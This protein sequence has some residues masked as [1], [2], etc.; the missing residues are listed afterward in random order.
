MRDLLSKTRRTSLWLLTTMIHPWT[1]TQSFPTQNLATDVHQCATSQKLRLGGTGLLSVNVFKRTFE[2]FS[3]LSLL[4]FG[5]DLKTSD[6][7]TTGDWPTDMVPPS[8]WSTI[9][10]IIQISL[11][12][13][14]L[15]CAEHI[16]LRSCLDT[17]F[18]K[19]LW[20]ELFQYLRPLLNCNVVPYFSWVDDVS[21]FVAL[22]LFWIILI[23]SLIKSPSMI[24]KITNQVTKE[25]L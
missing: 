25:Q 16:M 21:I 13:L 7:T 22:V 2:L 5:H 17:S 9:P 4:D 11:V 3:L 20:E 1:H 19:K 18:R 8:Y 23:I 24:Q 14:K 10:R 12:V 6:N 15:D